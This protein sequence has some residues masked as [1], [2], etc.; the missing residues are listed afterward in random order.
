M[1]GYSV[2]PPSG[3]E[4]PSGDASSRNAISRTNPTRV[5]ACE[6][7]RRRV[8]L[9][10][11]VFC[12]PVALMGQSTMTSP[13]AGSTFACASQT[14][15]WTA[16][17]GA[18]Y[19]QI[20]VGTTGAGS[21]NV[22][23]SGHVTTT[24]LTIN[25][26]PI[27]GAT[28]YVRLYTEVNE[29]LYSID[30]TYTAASLTAATLT[31]P[32]SGSTF[33]S[34]SQTFTWTSAAQATSYELFLGSTGPGSYNVYYSGSLTST[35]AAVTGLPINGE[36]IY[37]TLYTYFNSTRVSKSYTFTS[38]TIAPAALTSPTTGTT[39]ASTSQ[40]FTWTTA[41]GAT[42][43]E[44]FLGSTGPG[45]YNVYYSGH[46]TGT[47]AA[48]TGLPI[49]GETIY[50]RV[51][52]WF[53]S[54]L[55]YNDYTFTA[56]TIAP[57]ALTSPMTGSTFASTTQTFNWTPATSA[58][59][60]ELFLGS[61][62]PGSYNLYYS[63]ALTGTSAVV[64]GLPINGETIFAT[65]YTRFGTNLVSERYTFSAATLNAAAITSPVTGSTFAGTSQTFT[66]A[67]A[68]GATDYELF[69]GSTGP[70]SYNLYYSGNVTVNSLTVSGLPVNGETIY[71]TLYTRFNS[72]L[73]SNAYTYASALSALSINATSVGFGNVVLN[74]PTSQAVILTS[75]GNVAV[76]VNSATITGTGYTLTEPTLPAVLTTGQTITL[77]VQFD[78]TTTG[79]ANGQ[80]TVNSTSST[81]GTALIP[82]SGT[83]MA[84]S[85]A[86]NLSWNAPTNSP[87]PVVGYNVYRAP[88]NSS[89]YQLLNSSVDAETNYM[90]SSVTSGETYDYVVESVDNLGVQSAPTS[91]VSVT[92]P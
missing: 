42:S 29:R 80:L 88:S 20:L 50:G 59:N 92:I 14:F 13:T 63:G 52:T 66:W 15:A 77:G 31:S 24:S 91:P 62:G 67:P 36:T 18:S 78:P 21:Y 61:T 4:F 48:V 1:H 41:T 22:L 35:S 46:L 81:G 89:T 19:Y 49:N 57:A 7:I 8:L 58:T 32:T 79:L 5:E 69:V 3:R 85:Y 9:L 53:N 25:S 73:A 11:L 12:L 40:T 33:A 87:V 76:T 43:Y 74:T 26:M 38:A 64:T 90:D 39:F 28:V 54:T 17:T 44:L 37:A 70:G 45:S 10:F 71:A 65:L 34:T 51:Y 2:R 16:T 60:Y 75:I 6:R 82:L 56:A 23:D 30:Y 27:N 72:T 86:V 68:A 83:G 84:A 47:S 55:Y